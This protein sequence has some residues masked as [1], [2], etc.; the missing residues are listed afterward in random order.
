MSFLCSSE[1]PPML[2]KLV[3]TNVWLVFHGDNAGSNPAGAAR[4]FQRLTGKFKNRLI[5]KMVHTLP[6]PSCQSLRCV[7]SSREIPVCSHRSSR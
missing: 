5:H 2:C 7:H 3:K 6:E 4:S 1:L